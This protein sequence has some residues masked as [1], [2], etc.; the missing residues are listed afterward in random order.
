[1]PYSKDN[2]PNTMKNLNEEVR[3]K[4]IEILN[5]HLYENKMNES[6]AIPTAI[7]RARDWANNQGKNISKTK[8]DQKEHGKDLYVLP[9]DDQWS[10]K[11]EEADK[12]SFIFDTKDEAVEKAKKLAKDKHS[13]LIISGKSEV[14]RKINLITNKN[15]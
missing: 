8:A 1:M 4:A 7:S 3:K 5:A 10:V 6:F 2:Y 12:S 11:Y 15:K 14:F 9:K 13:K